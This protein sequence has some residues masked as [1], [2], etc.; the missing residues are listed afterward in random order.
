MRAGR[1]KDKLTF[2]RQNTTKNTFGERP[3]TWT[4]ICVRRAAI[5]PLMGKEFYANS[6][7]H[8]RLNTRIRLRHDSETETIR[9]FDRAVDKT[10]SPWV[11]YDI[12]AVQNPRNQDR[13]LVLM[14]QSNG[15]D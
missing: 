14:A 15:R 12:E 9:P 6:G 8:S 11:Y 1:L 2:E 3:D 7:E 10:V 4:E 13:E 5:E